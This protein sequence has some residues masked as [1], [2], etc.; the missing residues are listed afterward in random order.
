MNWPDGSMVRNGS[1]TGHVL[2]MAE[3]L[4]AIELL[5]TATDENGRSGERLIVFPLCPKCHCPYNIPSH[6]D[7]CEGGLALS[8]IGATIVPEPPNAD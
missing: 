2:S 8:S 5:S 6:P 7:R 4:E 3:L 1:R